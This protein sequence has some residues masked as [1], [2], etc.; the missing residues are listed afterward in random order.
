MPN[1]RLNKSVPELFTIQNN[2]LSCK[3]LS[4]NLPANSSTRCISNK[5]YAF[6][7]KDKTKS[8]S[9]KPD[10]APQSQAQ[11]QFQP[12]PQYQP[13]PQFQPES[14]SQPQSQKIPPVQ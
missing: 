9:Q 13:Q 12:Q 1:H 11:P 10:K 4:K 7:E 8:Q 6:I 3:E 5:H 2:L 14:Q